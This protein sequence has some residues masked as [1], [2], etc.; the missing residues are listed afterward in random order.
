MS[1][2][3]KKDDDIDFRALEAQHQLKPF[4]KRGIDPS[5]SDPSAGR[6]SLLICLTGFGDQRDEIARRVT[7]NGGQ[8]TG[9]LTRRCTHLVVSKPE[10]KKFVAAKAWGIYTVTLA[11]LHQSIARGMILEEAKFDPVL[12]PE[13]QGK[14]AWVKRDPRV[15]W[16]KRSR[17]A[18]AG[19]TEDG[20][21]KLRKTASMKLNSQRNNLWGDI[22]GRSTSREYSFAGEQ[23]KQEQPQSNDQ[24]QQEA[25]PVP[26][27]PAQQEQQGVFAYC[28]FFIHGF[29]PQRTDILDQTIRTL[30]GN[31]CSFLHEA[32][33]G[34]Y[35]QSGEPRGRFLLVPQASQP[36]T[37]PPANYENLYIVTEYYIERC[38]HNKA[39][40]EPNEQVL[41]RP[42]PLF[43]IPGFAD[44]TVCSAAFTGI[45]LHQV[46]RSVAQLGA[47]F[48][49]EFR[50]GT[51]VLVCRSLAA[52][53]KEKLRMAVKWGVPVVPADWLWE[54]IST[55]FKAPLDDFVFPELKPH[56]ALTK[57]QR[58]PKSESKPKEPAPSAG[59][60]APAKAIQ[61]TRSEPALRRASSKAPKGGVD[62]SGFDD[63]TPKP[64]HVTKPQ[65]KDRLD[66][67]AFDD[68]KP[69]PP[70]VKTN[71]F[72]SHVTTV[73]ADFTTALT[74]PA[75]E[76]LTAPESL[77]QQIPDS[78]EVPALCEAS[79]NRLN[80]SPSPTKQNTTTTT[81]TTATGLPRILSEPTKPVTAH[82]S[83]P[84]EDPEAV[85]RKLQ[86]QA[87]AAAL[88]R[89]AR[90]KV[91]AAERQALASK[92][93]SLIPTASTGSDDANN[94][95]S[96]NKNNS[97]NNGAPPRPRRQV[98]GRA[99]S[100][101][102]NASSDAA[103][104]DILLREH[105]EPA[106]ATQIEYADPRAQECKAA[107]MSR[108]MMGG[109]AVVENKTKVVDGTA[110]RGG[111]AMKTR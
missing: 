92:L 45:E 67:S 81:T 98:L 69:Q 32:A 5:L 86:L 54:C 58:Q 25:H 29:T 28:Y 36:A 1:E 66:A 9:D 61:R 3:W 50:R 72:T 83:P 82:T 37:H 70:P 51:S 80:R 10:G 103:R 4:E 94:E 107:L 101:V 88:D 104:S 95:P 8:Y 56:Y 13:E 59:P 75:P 31:V 34:P 91:K 22:L 52:A 49:E 90:N 43:P 97:N 93:T 78:E 40:L 110:Q 33:L 46:S 44:L 12:P 18:A 21:R 100:N 85:K 105:V 96:S 38:L 64:Q 16:G 7:E 41:G 99:I 27:I 24:P 109:G 108:M 53:R 102:S 11:W 20:P 48:Q 17:S 89:E 76:S 47:R 14:G 73:S 60:R 63:D 2:L 23:D 71:P 79:S 39:F 30:G 15:A 6:D 42:F 35:P 55:G 62:T 87:A 74:H 26:T 19:G 57:E 84:P 65:T 77:P 111:R 68:D 106:P